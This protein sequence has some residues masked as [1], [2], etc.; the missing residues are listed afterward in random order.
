MK[1][2]Q[3]FGCAKTV[4]IPADFLQDGRVTIAPPANAMGAFFLRFSP[5]K[6]L[7]CLFKT[8]V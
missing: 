3:P 1:P 7:D 4:P 8:G 5:A 6:V 2:R